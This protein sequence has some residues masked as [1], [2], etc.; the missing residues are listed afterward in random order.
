MA[1]VMT[2]LETGGRMKTRI[3]C[4]I[5]ALAAL[6]TGAFAQDACGRY[7]QGSVIQQP[8]DLYSKN[9]VLKVDFTYQTSPGPNGTPLYCFINSDGVQSPTLHIHPGDTLIINLTNLL[10][11][12]SGKMPNM[13]EIDMARA[14]E[15]GCGDTNMTSSSVNIHFHG[16]NTAPVCH[17]D[18]VIHTIINPDETFRYEVHFPKDEPP[19]LYWYH[20][21]IHGISTEAV[22][23][24]ATG[25]I[26]VDGIE[27]VNPAVAGLPQRILVVRDNQPSNPPPVRSLDNDAAAD[28]SINYVPVGGPAYIPAVMLMKSGAKEFWRVVNSSAVTILDLQLLYDDE[29]QPMQ[30]IALDGVAIGSQDGSGQGTS[31]T[32]NHL[33]I[34][35]AG[36]VEFIVKGPDSSVQKAELF[37][38]KIDTGPAGDPDPARPIFTITQSDSA[39]Q[40]SGLTNMPAPSGTPGPQRFGGLAEAKPTAARKLYFSEDAQHF[41][42]TVAGQKPRP[43]HP[44]EP[45]AIVT[46]QGSVEDWTIENHSMED[47]EF[48]IHQIHFLLLERNGVPLPE[49][50]QQIL[51]TVNVPYWSG[52]G[53]YTNVKV[54]LD[55][56]GPVVG[57]FVYHCH[58]LDH[59]DAGMMAIIRVLP[60]GKK[61]PDGLAQTK[62]S[63]RPPNEHN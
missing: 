39:M 62:V 46:T 45:P 3:L 60:A 29:P 38:R 56:R 53:P 59:E 51:D 28:L 25:A 12:Q 32:R 36:R 40:K 1:I 7:P 2:R 49:N 63:R 17:Q 15:G 20:P 48:H 37:T 55:F 61:S 6:P 10:P 24:G 11:P 50:E 47:H 5:G 30:V 41:Y 58:I 21:H 19:G 23:G 31:F 52:T 33:F 14:G 57:D 44:N 13:P 43:F 35:P 18:E 8:E 54:R 16:T 42:I 22:Q 34:P 4:T 27:N 9:G 26:V